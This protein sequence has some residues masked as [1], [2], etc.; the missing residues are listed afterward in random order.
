MKSDWIFGSVS[1]HFFGGSLLLKARTCLQYI[2]TMETDV[3][4][5]RA[6]R[7]KYLMEQLPIPN[8]YF[9]LANM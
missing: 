6:K 9:K 3:L 8:V 2:C 1:F 4:L 7:F 5:H